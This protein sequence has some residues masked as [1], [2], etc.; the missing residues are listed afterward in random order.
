MIKLT[1]FFDNPFWIGIFERIEN[2]KIQVCRVVFGQ[3][4]KDYEVY[5]FL[6]KNYFKLKFSRNMILDEKP[7]LKVN[8]KRMQREIKKSTK[9]KGI[10]T[11]AQQALKLDYEN[12]KGED[13]LLSKEKREIEEKI[14]FQKRQQK[15]KEK[16]KGH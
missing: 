7:Q 1:V 16:K 13:K 9:E 14:K 3:E 10:S 4:P 5:G 15:K 12:K 8:P 2:D 6:L 11:K